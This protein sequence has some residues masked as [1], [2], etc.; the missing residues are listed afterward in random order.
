[1]PSLT[2]FIRL[3]RGNLQYCA[4]LGR[5]GHVIPAAVIAAAAAVAVLPAPSVAQNPQPVP[6]GQAPALQ[7]TIGKTFGAWQQHCTPTPPPGTAPQPGADSQEACFIGQQYIDPGSQRP[8]LKVTIG[9]FGAN[10]Q[11]GAVIAFPLGVPL[12][13]GVQINVDGKALS[14]VPFQF[15]RRDG[16]Q[17]FMLM[18][19]EVVSAFKAGSQAVFTLQSSQNEVLDIPLSLSGFTAGFD[20]IK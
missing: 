14:P 11:T 13:R 18:S 5:I 8:V 9:F 20:S 10:R 7:A 12:A 16:C 6:Q 1:M 3:L 4:G 19:D 17:A 15:C 2:A